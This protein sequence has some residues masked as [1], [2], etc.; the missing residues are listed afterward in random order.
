MGKDQH[1]LTDRILNLTLEIIFVLT[2]EDY[3]PVKKCNEN[4]KSSGNSHEPG[5]SSE[6]QSPVRNP[7]PQSLIHERTKEQK[8]L[9]L[10][11]KIIE[12]LTGEVPIRCQDVTVHFSMEEWDY[13]EGQ[14][15]LYK[16]ILTTSPNL[17][18][19]LCELGDFHSRVPLL[20]H[21]KDEH[22]FFP[23]TQEL[24]CSSVN[25]NMIHHWDT[26]TTKASSFEA[27]CLTTPPTW[28]IKE[29]K[30]SFIGTSYNEYDLGY[31]K[32]IN[33]CYSI[34]LDHTYP[35]T[36]KNYSLILDKLLTDSDIPTNLTQQDPTSQVKEEP[37][38]Y[39][40]GSL[41]YSD[42]NT[43]A[44]LIQ[45]KAVHIKEE[46]VPCEENPS[47][48]NGMQEYQCTPIKEEPVSRDISNLTDSYP[49]TGLTRDIKPESVSDLGGHL[50]NTAHYN[51]MYQT[52]QN[53]EHHFQE[54]PS[55]IEIYLP[56][57]TQHTN[58][59]KNLQ[60]KRVRQRKQT[61]KPFLCTECGKS[62]LCKSGLSTHKKIHMFRKPHTCSE[63]GKSFLSH[64]Y[65][66]RHQKLH[67][68]EKTHSCEEA[69][70]FFGK[71][72][73]VTKKAPYCCA[74]CGK[75]FISN[76][77][78]IRHQRSHGLEKPFACSQCDKWFSSNSEL[79]G[80]QR[81]HSEGKTFSCPDCGKSFIKFKNLLRH[82]RLHTGKNPFSCIECGKLFTSNTYLLRHMKLHTSKKTSYPCPT[83][84]KYFNSN[85][86]LIIHQRIHAA[87][88]PGTSSEWRNCFIRKLGFVIHQRNHAKE[89]PF[90]CPECKER[91]VKKIHL[92]RHQK[93]HSEEKSLQT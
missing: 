76:S 2:G 42:L 37:Q 80:H 86:D 62:F 87:G 24:R 15:D 14:K 92:F 41:T 59:S 28:P 20:H 23:T 89:K 73:N 70:K 93:V 33:P 44:G 75:R 64:S 56:A 22:S 81:L 78:L 21:F 79:V 26:V 47:V 49:S 19:A 4:V 74:R 53:T 10:T 13:I 40:E 16:D 77:Y 83:C 43:S 45:Y 48:A 12:L 63:C 18:R 3:G 34:F 69:A 8:V 31:K 58:S 71:A 57:D 46:P 17:P 90:S 51:P 52:H 11:N 6:S 91:F 85:L 39:G 29:D 5:E 54:Q 68:R 60:R 35:I 30:P 82:Q 25:E 1:Q 27:R 88:K 72:S 65:L 36:A 32:S 66:V 61:D 38:L 50:E 9:D 55:E 67:S 7:P 84:G